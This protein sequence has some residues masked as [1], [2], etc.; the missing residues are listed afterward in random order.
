MKYF[1]IVTRWLEDI[2]LQDLQEQFPSVTIL[3]HAY[4]RIVFEYPGNPAD[5]LNLKSVD[6][7]FYYLDTVQVGKYREYLNTLK[8]FIMRAKMG[9]IIAAVG[10]MRDTNESS[11]SVSVSNVGDKNYTPKEIKE[12]LVAGIGSAFERHEKED[13]TQTFNIRVFI[14]KE[15]CLIG[16]RVGL[17]P[18]HRR[19]YK[20]TTLPGSL[21]APVAYCMLKIADIKK[22][23]VVLDPMCGVGTIVFEAAA[24][25][26]NII[27]CDAN[28]DA[29]E[30][31]QTSNATDA[32]IAFC[33]LD[34]RHTA[35]EDASVHHI[36]SNLPFG[37]Q[38]ELEN[39]ETFFTEII[40]EFAR[41][42]KPTGNMV[43]LTMHKDL[44]AKAAAE[45]GFNIA[46]E[47]EISLFGV[48]PTIVLV[49]KK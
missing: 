31:A 41:V 14:E 34:A 25:T 49:Q 21:K 46:S 12:V 30:I 6:D 19:D 10:K 32:D 36:V 4:K 17:A 37:K 38:I 26:S 27:A 47:R 44:I 35:L 28:H 16:V 15:E 45:Q 5:L 9:H 42:L 22:W 48:N 29:L 11:F 8:E 40:E 7:V 20:T 39:A 1:A 23:D 24:L 18:L 2:A 43:L 13:G 3:S 33:E